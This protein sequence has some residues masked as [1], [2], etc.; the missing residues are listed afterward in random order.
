M[1]NKHI[2]DYLS[3]VNEFNELIDKL[4]RLSLNLKKAY[5]YYNNQTLKPDSNDEYY[6]DL[7]LRASDDAMR[8]NTLKKTICKN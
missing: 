3:N 8:I 7:L 5:D 2:E 6:L 4:D 1:K